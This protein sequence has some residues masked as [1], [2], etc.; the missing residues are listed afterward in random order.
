[1]DLESGPEGFRQESRG[2]REAGMPQQALQC[3]HMTSLVS[4]GV[5]FAFCSDLLAFS[6][7]Y[8]SSLS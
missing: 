6:S 2:R 3:M 5:S 8:S 7:V 4:C 1:M